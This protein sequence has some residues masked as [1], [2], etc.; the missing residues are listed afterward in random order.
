MIGSR[1]ALL[2]SLALALAG[3]G[4]LPPVPLP[5]AAYTPAPATPIEGQFEV[6]DEGASIP[7]RSTSVISADVSE[8]Y[9]P[10]F[11]GAVAASL[12]IHLAAR[13]SG[14]G[15]VKVRALVQP[16]EV[17]VERG[18]PDIVPGA[19]PIIAA[20]RQRTFIA[21]GSVVFEVERAGRVERTYTLR[22]STRYVGSLV[23]DGQRASSTAEAISLWQREAFAKVDAEFLGRYL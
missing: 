4:S 12:R 13:L 10:R 5:I 11:S 9:D 8:L 14:A 18:A 23:T 3:C 7:R 17:I 15:D 19:G 2:I 21:T 1:R 20:L 6:V 16:G 22:H